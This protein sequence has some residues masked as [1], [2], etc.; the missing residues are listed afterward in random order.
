MKINKLFLFGIF[1]LGYY[2]VKGLAASEL[3]IRSSRATNI[4]FSLLSLS[5]D[6]ELT[7]ENFRNQN[8]TVSGIGGNVYLNNLVVATTLRNTPFTI[9]ANNYTAVTIPTVIVYSNLLLAAQDYIKNVIAQK[10]GLTLSWRGVVSSLGL[11][12]PL[13]SDFKVI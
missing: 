3:G 12:F 7:F 5:F 6:L 11:R 8:L 10:A 9:Q 1:A 2:A 13:Q 4:K